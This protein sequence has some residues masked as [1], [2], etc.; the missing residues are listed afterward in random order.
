[1][2][3]L[4]GFIHSQRT[5]GQARHPGQASTRWRFPADQHPVERIEAAVDLG[6]SVPIVNPASPSDDSSLPSN[7]IAQGDFHSAKVLHF[8]TETCNRLREPQQTSSMQLPFQAP[9]LGF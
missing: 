1:M 2:R 9:D 8:E 7:P 3:S 6:A 5:S 4:L